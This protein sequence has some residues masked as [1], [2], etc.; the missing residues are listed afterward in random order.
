MTAIQGFIQANRRPGELGVHSR[1]SFPLRRARPRGRAEFLRRIRARARR[2]RQSA[3][4][5][6]TFGSPHVWGTIGEGPRKKLGYLSFGAF[7][8]D[9]DEFRRAAA[10]RWASKRLDPPP[11]VDS[12]GSGFSITTAS[13]SRSR[14]PR[15]PRPTRKPVSLITRPV[16][17]ERGAPYRSA[18]AADLSAPA[19][20][21]AD[22]HR[23][24]CARH[25]ILHP[26][27]RSAAVRSFRRQYRFS[28]WHPRQRSSHG[29]LCPLERARPPS[30]QLGRRLHRRD[31][32]RCDA[33]AGQGL[34]QGLG[35]RPACARFELFPLRPGP[36]GQLLANIPPTSITFRSTTDWP[37]EDHP[38]EDSF[39]AWGPNVPEDFV[40]NYEA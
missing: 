12:N 33:H 8:D 13:W 38:A 40:H 20:A 6:R 22:V 21:C 31:R 1:R 15:N 10:G 9:I 25:R 32:R 30:F 24:M 34:R 11:G 35:S 23:A 19:R 29:R 36:V 4:A 37:S 3:D 17:G 28:A 7:E 2:E 39:Y 16:P 26:G 27:A 18:D 5:L 14:S